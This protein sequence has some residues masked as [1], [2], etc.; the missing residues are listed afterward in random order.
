MSF[1]DLRPQMEQAPHAEMVQA[2]A[3]LKSRLRADSAANRDDLARRHT[4]IETGRKVRWEDLK[5]ELGL[6]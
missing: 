3:F 1:A 4:E 2:L 5:R 6:P